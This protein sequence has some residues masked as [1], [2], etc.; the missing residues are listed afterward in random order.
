MVFGV[1]MLFGLVP[2]RTSPLFAL[3]F[4]VLSFF[5]FCWDVRRRRFY[6]CFPFS[7]RCWGNPNPFR[8]WVSPCVSSSWPRSPSS[9]RTPCTAPT[10][11]FPPRLV[12]F[13]SRRRSRGCFSGV[14]LAVCLSVCL[15][16][17]LCMS[18]LHVRSLIPRYFGGR[19][20]IISPPPGYDHCNVLG[21]GVRTE[22]P[23]IPCTDS[24]SP[25][26]PTPFLQKL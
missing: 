12:F 8:V 2:F 21:I 23:C 7:L 11:R 10:S 19:E 24:V 18:A 16:V 5:S 6:L 15:S 20:T 25:P 26:P 13:F 22:V 17:C 4:V 9:I 14:V 1:E 3:V